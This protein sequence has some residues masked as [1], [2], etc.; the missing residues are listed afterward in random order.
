MYPSLLHCPGLRFVLRA[1]N[2]DV[3]LRPSFVILEES[4]NDA[5]SQFP[6]CKLWITIIS[7]PHDS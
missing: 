5:Q 1:E 2:L 3:N 7:T 6:I 4:L